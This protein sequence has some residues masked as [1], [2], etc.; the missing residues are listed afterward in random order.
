L[1][2][3][4][5]E[6]NEIGRQAIFLLQQQFESGFAPVTCVIPGNIV[7]RK[8]LKPSSKKQKLIYHHKG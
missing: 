5:E 4:T 6:V 3:V 7:E 2:S 8:S 1:T